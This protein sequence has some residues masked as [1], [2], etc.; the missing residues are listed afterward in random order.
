MSDHVHPLTKGNR[1][2]M[3]ALMHLFCVGLPSTIF[4]ALIRSFFSP[5]ARRSAFALLRLP[6]SNTWAGFHLFLYPG[7]DATYN[8]SSNYFGS[9]QRHLG[10]PL[11]YVEDIEKFREQN[12]V[13]YAILQQTNHALLKND[14]PGWTP[15]QIPD[16]P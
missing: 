3:R 5:K 10:F 13:D 11:P 6:S 12:H 8:Y 16:G 4:H 2:H 1:T 7:V 15:R 9:F 14:F